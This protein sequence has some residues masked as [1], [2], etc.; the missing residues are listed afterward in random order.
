[1]AYTAMA[2][3]VVVAYVVMAYIVMACIVMAWCPSSAPPRASPT[4]PTRPSAPRSWAWRRPRP[5]SR[6]LYIGSISASPTACLLRRYGRAGT[7]NCRLGEA[8]ILSTGTPIPAQWRCRR[9]RRDGA[10]TSGLADGADTALRAAAL[11]LAA[12]A[13]FLSRCPRTIGPGLM[14]DV[15]RASRAVFG[16]SQPSNQSTE[17][18]IGPGRGLPG[19]S[20]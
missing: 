10:D 9:R 7:Q 5:C 1:M 4:A 19:A 3:I 16:L 13:V 17:T 2:Q 12:A 18:T 8:G 6:A 20:Y 14:A 15:E 11:G